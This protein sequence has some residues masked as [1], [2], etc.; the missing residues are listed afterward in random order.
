MATNSQDG[1]FDAL[2][3]VR[4][5]YLDTGE[6]PWP[7]LSNVLDEMKVYVNMAFSN[8]FRFSPIQSLMYTQ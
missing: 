4:E 5:F 2:G 1:M 6:I 7:L 3:T 8:Y